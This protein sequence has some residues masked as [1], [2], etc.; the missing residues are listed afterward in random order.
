MESFSSFI[1]FKDAVAQ[2]YCYS[3]SEYEITYIPVVKLLSEWRNPYFQF[4]LCVSFE[5]T[6]KVFKYHMTWKTSQFESL[7]K[8]LDNYIR[9]SYRMN[10][11]KKWLRR[12]E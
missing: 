2:Y 8:D 4:V 11:A 5:R 7:V 1:D 12:E 6:K 10:F 3:N 9:R